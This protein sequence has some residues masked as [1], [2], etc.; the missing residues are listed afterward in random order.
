V[1]N[2]L[3]DILNVVDGL[4][5]SIFLGAVIVHGRRANPT[6]PKVFEVIDGQQRLTTAFLFMAALVKVLAN[7]KEFDEASKL[8]QNYLQIGRDYRVKPSHSF[9]QARS[10]NGRRSNRGCAV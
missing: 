6:S 4:L 8:A 10:L 2:L 7:I 3:D 5:T 1:N 9:E